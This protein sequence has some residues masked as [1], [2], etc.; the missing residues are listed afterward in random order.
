MNTKVSDEQILELRDRGLLHREIAEILGLKTCTI[1]S[2]LIKLGRKTYTVDKEKVEEL[3][4]S[5]AKDAEIAEMLGCS[6]SNVTICLNKMG[7]TNRKSKIDD[8]ELRDR[9][10]NALIGRYTGENNPNYKGHL[11]EKQIARGLCKTISRRIMRERGFTCEHCGKH[12]GNL[13]M[14]HIKPFN[15]IFTEFISNRYNKDINTI[16]Q[17]LMSYPDFIDESNMVILCHKCH[18]FVHYSDNPELSPYRW[19]SATTIE[20]C[21]EASE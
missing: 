6:R 19:E 2:R 4:L 17:Q 7:Y 8:I 5:G 18:R 13:E 21:Q 14:H 9:I 12:G 1:T 15:I 11:N 10:S 16:Y 3:H 20:N